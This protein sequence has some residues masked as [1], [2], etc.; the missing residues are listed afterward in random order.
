[1]LIGAV[2]YGQCDRQEVIEV[3]DMTIVDGD[4]DGTPDGIINLY[5]EYFNLTGTNIEQGTWV[6]P[7]FDFAL[8]TATGDL[9]TW[10]LN[11]ASETVDQYTYV[12]YNNSCGS[13]PALTL[14]VVL[15][16]FSGFALPPS[17]SSSVNF[18]VCGSQTTCVDLS[19]IDLNLALQSDPSPH[20]NGTWIYEGSSPNFIQI[21]DSKLYVEVPYQP[22]PPLVDEETFVVTYIVPG[23]LP[24]APEQRTNV[25]VSVVRQVSSGESQLT[26]ICEQDIIDGLYD[27]DID[28][29]NDAYLAFEDIEGIWSG[30]ANTGTEISTPSDHTINIRAL[31]DNLIANNPRFGA[32]RFNFRYEVDQRS[33]VCADAGSDVPFIILEKLRPFEQTEARVICRDETA[34]TTINLYD[35]LVFTTENGVTY[36]YNGNQCTNWEFVS[37]PSDLGLVSHADDM[38]S[39]DPN[40]SSD[41]TIDLSAAATGEY[42]FRYT[43][44]PFINCG[45][46]TSFT[47]E[48]KGCDVS[49]ENPSHLCSE[50]SALVT[51]RITDPRYAGEDTSGIEV[52]DTDENLDL[53]TLLE[54]NGT[55]VYVGD[56]GVWTDEDDNE[57]ANAFTIPAVSGQQTFTF[58]YTTG[59]VGCLD[60]ATLSF[61]VYESYEVGTGTSIEV[62][63]DAAAFQLFD[64]LTG[65]TDTNGTWQGPDGY[66]TT[67][68]EGD[69]NP[70]E[71]TSGAYVYTIA[72][73]GPCPAQE[74]TVN[75]TVSTIPNAGE[76]LQFTACQSD[77]L[78][79]L[80]SLLSDDA[81]MDGVFTYT[82]S[83]DP[84]SDALLD[85]TTATSNIAITYT[86]NRENACA[87]DSANW[88]ITVDSVAAPTVGT[89]SFCILEGATLRDLEINEVFNYEWYSDESATNIISEETVLQN[90]TYYIRN[91]NDA[92]CYSTIIAVPVT[93]YNIGELVDC[94]PEIPDGVSPNG[95][96]QNDSFDT[97]DLAVSF[98]NFQL[99][100]YNRYGTIVY[101]GTTTTNHFAGYANV[102]PSLGDDLPA[103][104]YYY[105]FEPN[106]GLNSPFQGSFYL[107][108]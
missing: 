63:E 33:L 108:K 16:P 6:D 72:A 103:G 84:V 60:T 78:I 5:D 94:K 17:G 92:G 68:F 49:Y 86:I 35:E 88:V 4:N 24:C 93:I 70:A 79:D 95:D 11:R 107:S 8:D 30:S 34:P 106:D 99:S 37:G 50:E 1:M 67:S 59:V 18:Q 26:R 62:C 22:G 47:Y 98:P 58:T 71:Q 104:V 97:D 45:Q 81:D 41:G 82:D 101:K 74:V 38:C 105:V 29:F 10:D 7:N 55:P 83:G 42:V 56:E 31:Y 12:L 69:F 48:S 89:Y 39:E 61:T 21:V 54:T 13:T 20:L 90:T 19:D 73:N 3:C 87:V 23:I 14:N 28:L 77:Q 96:G 66:T 43:V 44:S 91:V 25:N 85:I 32:E 15:G 40:Y 100:I 51:L 46:C 65:A 27:A 9:Y 52:C 64:L 76:D 36:E 80:F 57:I 2:S 102:S 75:V 53:V